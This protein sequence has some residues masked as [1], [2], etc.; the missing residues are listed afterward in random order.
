MALV[1]LSLWRGPMLAAYQRGFRS[2]AKP[3][4]LRRHPSHRSGHIDLRD[5]A[6]TDLQCHDVVPLRLRGDLNRN[7]RDDGRV[8]HRLPGA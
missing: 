4:H 6:H 3:G 5:P 2:D 8:T 7:V 1:R